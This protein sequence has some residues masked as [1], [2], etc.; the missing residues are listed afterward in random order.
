MALGIISTVFYC[1]FLAWL[2]LNNPYSL[3]PSFPLVKGDQ[4]L[5]LANLMGT[6]FSTQT[7]LIEILR[8]S[9]EGNNLR[10]VIYAFTISTL[11]Y[12]YVGWVGGIGIIDIKCLYS[13]P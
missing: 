2:A 6:A 7:M 11:I 10:T 12:I 5:T 8:I 1:F 9:P 4:F 13:N 3:K